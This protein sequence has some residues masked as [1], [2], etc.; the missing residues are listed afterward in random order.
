[1]EQRTTPETI[2]VNGIIELTK[3]AYGAEQFKKF[4]SPLETK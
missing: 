3:G 2:T 1:M 4:F